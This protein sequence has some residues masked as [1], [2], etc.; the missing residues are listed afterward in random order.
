MGGKNYEVYVQK[1]TPLWKVVTNVLFSHVG[2]F[3]LVI[4]Y[5]VGGKW[6]L[7]QTCSNC[8]S[9]KYIEYA[10]LLIIETYWQ[11]PELLKVTVSPRWLCATFW[12]SNVPT[13]K[14]MIFFF[15]LYFLSIFTY[16]VCILMF[17]L[18]ILLRKI[19]ISKIVTGLLVAIVSQ[20][21]QMPI[22]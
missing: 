19:F 14:F 13:G 15:F 17:F 21:Q 4:G 9:I 1:G 3:L 7:S 20:G 10:K 5:C 18:P 8:R 6:R 11:V 2:L 22:W 16:F 12:D